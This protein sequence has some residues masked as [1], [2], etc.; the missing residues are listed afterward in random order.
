MEFLIINEADA[1]KYFEAAK[2]NIAERDRTDF[3]SPELTE[4][5]RTEMT[6]WANETCAYR[7]PAEKELIKILAYYMSIWNKWHNALLIL[8]HEL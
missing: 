5:Q 7:T 2:E 4:E 6:D 3:T 1:P 8:E